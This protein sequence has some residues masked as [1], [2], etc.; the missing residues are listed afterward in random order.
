M[1]RPNIDGMKKYIKEWCCGRPDA[2]GIC[3]SGC[4]EI[5]SLINYI[6]YLE[7]APNLPLNGDAGKPCCSEPGK[8]KCIQC[9]ELDKPVV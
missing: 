2:S 3:E 5:T 8:D 1:E 6:E 7:N 4:K 9:Q